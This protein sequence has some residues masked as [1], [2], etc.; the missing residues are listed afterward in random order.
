MS[1]GSQRHKKELRLARIRSG[2]LTT[3]KLTRPQRS[4]LT[5]L[6]KIISSAKGDEFALAAALRQLQVQQLY[7][8][9]KSAQQYAQ[10]K[11]AIEERRY[12]Q[13]CKWARIEETLADAP[14][15][16]LNESSVPKIPTEFA[17]R[18]IA[19]SPLIDDPKAIKSVAAKVIIPGK[20]VTAARVSDAV[21][22]VSQKRNQKQ[23]A[24]VNINAK[25]KAFADNFICA[26]I[27]DGLP[28]LADDSFDIVGGSPPY[29]A[30][31]DYD[32]F[33]DGMPQTELLK[34]YDLWFRV[35]AKKVTPN[36]GR[37]WI[38][39]ADT[40]RQDR[41]GEYIHP[42][43]VR[44]IN[45][46]E[47]IEGIRLFQRIVW[48]RTRVSFAQD[49]NWGSKFSCKCPN[50]RRMHEH[51]LVFVRGDYS[52]QADP[53]LCDIT[54]THFKEWTKSV[55][56]VSPAYIAS[57]RLHPCPFPLELP[58]RIYK[59]YGQ[60][61]DRCLD[62]WGG[63]GTSALVAYRNHREFVSVDQSAKYTRLARKNLLDFINRNKTKVLK[64]PKQNS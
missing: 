18:R 52:R 4:E 37:I 5:K 59:L 57:H 63:C 33:N 29:G 10:V 41:D 47:R 19:D 3:V 42:L 36:G 25:Q 32:G 21:A 13:L 64:R 12:F 28:M 40:F 46:M 39:V 45:I 24:A 34:L 31:L 26:K 17:A 20:K 49:H 14:D 1:V 54:P 48:D 22:V 11:H 9:H 53:K 43:D 60:R 30:G 51:V 62:P 38:N 50:V 8:G 58:L 56:H 27:E 16:S 2:D 15:G 44:V 35:L 23:L 61:G 6:D 55:W 7:V